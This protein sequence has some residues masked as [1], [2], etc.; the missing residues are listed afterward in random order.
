MRIR[1]RFE[2]VDES[3]VGVYHIHCLT[4]R[5]AFIAGI[6]RVTAKQFD[7]RKQWI[8]DRLES[9][10]KVFAVDC[11]DH[12][13]LPQALHLILRNRP[14]VAAQWTDE[15]V[16]WRWLRVNRAKLELRAAPPPRQLAKLLS[17]PDEIAKVRRALSG[18][19]N[20]MASLRQPIAVL[21]NY[22]DRE[23][24]VFWVSRYGRRRLP[25]DPS[26]WR[27]ELYLPTSRLK[28]VSEDDS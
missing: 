20:Y 9:L 5:G 28:L 17:A 26:L 15:E 16:A 25:D 3:Q 7:Y 13:V 24:G 12:F 22:E 4:I 23:R 27:C 2:R 14:D 18:F 19:P 8:A 1:R 6:D 10:A 11:L 21:A